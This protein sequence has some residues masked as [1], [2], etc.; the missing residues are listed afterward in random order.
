MQILQIW[1]QKLLLLLAIT[2]LLSTSFEIR[3]DKYPV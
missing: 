1:R 2:R 3:K